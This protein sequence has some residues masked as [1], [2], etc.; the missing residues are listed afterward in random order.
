[1]VEV[2]LDES[3]IHD[4]AKICVIAGYVGTQG[5]LRRL[6][7]AW[8]RV[9]KRH[10]VKLEDFH[11]KDFIK[12]TKYGPLLKELARAIASQHRVIPISAGVI[13]DDFNAL[14]LQE[15]RFLTGGTLGGKSGK[16][17]TSGC[18]NKPYFIPFQQV[19]K[20]GTSYAPPGGKAHFSFGINNQFSGY[21]VA[22]FRQIEEQKKLLTSTWK[23]RDRLGSLQFP[24]AAEAAQ[25]QAADLFAH[26]TYLHMDSY[27]RQVKPS[28]LVADLLPQCLWNGK[29][30]E[31]TY[32]NKETL[33]AFLDQGQKLVPNWKR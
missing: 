15:R 21:A 3:G 7:A 2:Y 16:V 10:S 28:A 33:A 5:K 30:N 12:K 23:T 29:N 1:M 14:S 8:K 22:L 4:G 9:L 19:V 6:E 26:L 25:L 17:F 18:P 11:A 13:I 24:L 27:M 20:L 31:Q 32:H